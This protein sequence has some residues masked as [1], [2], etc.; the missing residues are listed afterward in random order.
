MKVYDERPNTCKLS[1]IRIG[2]MF[3]VAQPYDEDYKRDYWLMG[4]CKQDND[5][6]YCMTNL[7][8]GEVLKAHDLDS[9]S[10]YYFLGC[11]IKALETELN[12]KKDVEWVRWKCPLH[13]Y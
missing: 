4:L 9:A 13:K 12:I 3:E 7:R 11:R 10:K 5:K 6:E 8:T 2:E 1:D